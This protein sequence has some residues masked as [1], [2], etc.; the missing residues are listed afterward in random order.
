[1][2][3]ESQFF[4]E[5]VAQEVPRDS[6]SKKLWRR[7]LTDSFSGKLWRWVLRGSCFTNIAAQGTLNDMFS[8]KSWRRRF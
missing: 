4:A 1:M 8:Q 6:F 3:S 2:V 7:G 5:I